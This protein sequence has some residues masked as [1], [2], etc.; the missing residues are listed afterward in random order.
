MVHTRHSLNAKLIK[1][2]STD[3]AE[4]CW[5]LYVWAPIWEKGP[6]GILA[7]FV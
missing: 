5:M 2:A 4:W 1:K 3:F 7:V 6:S